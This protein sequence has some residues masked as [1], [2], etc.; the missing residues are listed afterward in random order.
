MVKPRSIAV[1]G[2]AET[3]KMGIVPEMS[4]LGLNIDC[5]LNAI[6]DAGLK[7]GDIDGI[8]TAN[9]HPWNVAA[10]LGITPRWLDGT[11]VG[12]CSFM[13]HV[14]HACAAIEAGLCNTVLVT[15]GESGRSQVAPTRYA[16]NPGSLIG[17]FELPYGIHA[18]VTQ[19]TIPALRFLK[20]TDTTQE[21]LARLVVIQREWAALNPRATRKEPVTVDEVM[22]DRM[23]AYPFRKSMC[24]VVTDGG[25]ALILTSAERAKD[26][27]TKPVYILG[28]GE[29]IEN[30]V[31]S[32][33]SDLTSSAA[34]RISGRQAFEEAGITHADVDHLMLYDAFAHVPFYM[35]EDLG[36]AG[37]GEAKYFYRERR[38]APGGELPINTSGGGLSYMHSG[39]YGMYAMQE[40]I[41]QMR[42]IAPAQV[43]GAKISVSHGVGNMFSGA[44]TIIFTNE[45]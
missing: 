26:F 22:N 28:T 27:P 15:H 8:A 24:C 35:L 38:C 2:A 20:D 36:F 44:G 9:E 25:G 37:R 21:D 32:M 42:G 19:F 18:P 13:L 43:E 40:S 29:G 12:G 1:V 23:I 7:P 16:A 34:F 3:T 33:M 41:R 30:P 11:N 17:Q 14:R 45:G 39:M 6:E 31:I 10:M 5:A 4:Q